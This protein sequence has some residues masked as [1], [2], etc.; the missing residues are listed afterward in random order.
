M[1]Q[2][3]QVLASNEHPSRLGAWG[4]VFA[5]V[6]RPPRAPHLPTSARPGRPCLPSRIPATPRPRAAVPSLHL[7]GQLHAARA[8]SACR[9][10]ILPP[11]RAEL[12]LTPAAPLPPEAVRCS[13]ESHTPHCCCTAAAPPRTSSPPGRWGSRTRQTR[14][15]P[16]RPCWWARLRVGPWG[17]WGCA[18]PSMRARRR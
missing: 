4:Q 9:G 17:S 15:H 6:P 5:A 11:A 2:Q 1:Q 3:Q 10:L 13:R 14:Q 7:P 8:H 16:T 12:Q 18:R